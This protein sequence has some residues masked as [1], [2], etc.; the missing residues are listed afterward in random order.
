MLSKSVLKHLVGTKYFGPGSYELYGEIKR[1]AAKENAV[2]NCFQ[3]Y[4][5]E[6]FVEEL[7]KAIKLFRSK[8]GKRPKTFLDVGCGIGHILKVASHK[9]FQLET[10][11]IELSATLAKYAAYFSP[12]S[13]IVEGNLFEFKAYNEFDIIFVFNPTISGGHKVLSTI[14][15][16]VK[17]K[18][19]IILPPACSRPNGYPCNWREINYEVITNLPL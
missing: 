5:T 3:P 8:T 13:M 6:R 19:C 14:I 10:T 4:Y 11:G 2:A 16:Q 7:T 12:T 1:E 15:K 9:Q 17:D 18:P